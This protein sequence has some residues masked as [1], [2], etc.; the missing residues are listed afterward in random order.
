[1]KKK[2]RYSDPV[3]AYAELELSWRWAHV[4]YNGIESLKKEDLRSGVPREGKHVSWLIA[5]H[6]E[7]MVRDQGGLYLERCRQA[8]AGREVPDRLEASPSFGG[9]F[10][11]WYHPMHEAGMHA[12]RRV[13]C[14]LGYSFPEL[15]YCP[16]LNDV[17]CCLVIFLPEGE[18]YAVAHSVLTQKHGSHPHTPGTKTEWR[19]FLSGTTR[20]VVKEVPKVTSH[21][22][23][24]G[25]NIAELFN[26]WLS[27]FF[28]GTLPYNTVLH[29]VDPYLSEG[30]KVLVRLIVAIFKVYGPTILKELG[31]GYS[32][33]GDR[34]AD[35]MAR[36]TEILSISN[37]LSTE[38]MEMTFNVRLAKDKAFASDDEDLDVSL[39]DDNTF[40]IPQIE[41]S[42]IMP[43]VSIEAVTSLWS[44]WPTRYRFLDAELLFSTS[45]DGTSMRTLLEKCAGKAPLL[46]LIRGR[47]VPK[48][49][50]L[51]TVLS[52]TTLVDRPNREEVPFVIGA[53]FSQQLGDGHPTGDGD[54]TVFTLSPERAIH[55][56]V[57][58]A[59]P[60]FVFSS[61]TDGLFV[62]ERSSP[63]LV[64]NANLETGRSNRCSTFNSPCLLGM[65]A[66]EYKASLVE[67]LHL[68]DNIEV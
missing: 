5:S 17:V 54:T 35:S 12:A 55:R 37:A 53:L 22:T 15:R 31:R 2:C 50:I 34:A 24:C 64:L 57:P 1:M 13:L 39:G 10:R 20:A 61:K 6:A 4:M 18:A 40:Y 33:T 49:K 60:H 28:V 8:F 41:G 38:V 44:M 26:V 3:V 63:A 67:V 68:N 45:R 58:T 43:A 32:G 7:V 11:P 62:G 36:L 66:E 52:L 9:E 65:D 23:A 14:T 27:T 21:L 48:K 19:R 29:L 51:Q 16:A 42:E 46:L 30:F 47:T 25:I 56:F 59:T